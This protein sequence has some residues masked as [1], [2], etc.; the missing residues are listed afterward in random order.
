M[1]D[2]R[3]AKAMAQTLRASLTVK[4]VTI[5]HSESLELVSKMFGVADWNTL[6]AQIVQVGR[7]GA[8]PRCATEAGRLPAMPLRHF[9][10]FPGGIVPLYANCAKTIQVLDRG[11][12]GARQIIVAI[13]R[14]SNDELGLSDVHDVGVLGSILTL[15]QLADGRWKALTQIHRRVM[16]KDFVGEAE[17]YVA[18]FDVLDEQPAPHVPDLI[19]RVKT[20]FMIHSFRDTIKQGYPSAPQLKPPFERVRDPGRLADMIASHTEFSIPDK[21]ALLA[22]LDPVKRLERVRD[23]L[24]GNA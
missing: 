3:D 20:Y 14:S 16:I 1:R 2:F 24:Q 13:Q 5:S 19:L 18:D 21:Q 12:Q 9:V 7:E 8:A 23:L 11:F 15:D 4:A 10:P 17:S 6:S 22:T